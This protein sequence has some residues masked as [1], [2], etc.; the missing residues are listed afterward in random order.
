MDIHQKNC[1][2]LAFEHLYRAGYNIVLNR[3]G[4]VLYD[5]VRD[6]E[7]DYCAKNVIPKIAAHVTPNLVNIALGRTAAS[8]NERREM[9]ET[10]LRRLRDSWEDHNTAMNMIADVL[11]YL[12]RGLV[13]DSNRPSIYTTTI[14]LYRDH[15]L[16]GPLPTSPD[17]TVSYILNCIIIDLINM[18]RDGDVIDRSL[19][20][21]CIRML[22]SLYKTDMELEDEKLYFTGFEPVFLDATETYYKMECDKLFRKGDTVAWLRH[23]DRRLQEEQDRCD[24]TI[25]RDT[26]KQCIKIVEKQLIARHLADFLRLDTGIVSMLD[27]DSLDELAIVYRLVRRVDPQKSVLHDPLVGRI[28][29]LGLEIEQTIRNTDFAS[30]AGAA[31]TADGEDGGTGG[32]GGTGGGADSTDKPSNSSNKKGPS[33]ASAAAQQTAAAIKWV[34]DV[35]QL[36]AKFDTMWERCFEKDLDIQTMLTKG[37]AIFINRFSRASEYLSLFIDDNLRRGIRGKT[38]KEIDEVL[39]KAIALLRYI[40]DRDM[41]ERYYQKHLAK[42]LLLSKS[43]S[44]DAETAMVS[45]M[46][47]ELGNQF[48]NKFEGM[49]R[50]MKTSAEI[51]ANYRTHVRD[52]ADSAS[53][54]SEK[55]D[56]AR[57]PELTVNILT[58]NCWPPEISDRRQVLDSSVPSQVIYPAEIQALQQNLTSFYLTTRSGRKLTWVSSMGSA[59]IRCVF[60]AIPGGKGPLARERRYELNVSTAGMIVLMLFN[61]RPDDAEALSFQEI[62]EKTG[63]QPNDLQRTLS[64]L[65]IPP[66]SRVLLKEPASRRV[67]TT[68]RFRFNAAFVSKT[69]RIRAPIVNATAKAETDKERKDTEEKNTLS[70]SHII[71][72]A[73]V[74]TMKYV[75]FFLFPFFGCCFSLFPH[76]NN[77]LTI[78]PGNARSSNTPSSS[79]RL[80]ASWP[81]ASTPKSVISRNG[82]RTSSPGSI[83]LAW[84]TSMS[85]RT[86]TSRNLL[87]VT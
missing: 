37:F 75:F 30:Q 17:H 42:R 29:D 23:T 85:P 16:H 64:S 20:R 43:E 2:K 56:H 81:A 84:R 54:S 65:T 73:I 21:S 36:K 55:E 32:T 5:R 18:E 78:A 51:T 31:A 39:D 53:S 22:D 24:T 70:R 10:F 25:H 12:D 59:D 13:Q 57:R 48:T 74:R 34:D 35:L 87:D 15:I 72:A 86:S 6:F 79:P 69:V 1:S 47:E 33:A 83:W 27:N 41:F 44:Q 14:G 52:L 8:A 11:M 9:H 49:F 40:R 7:Q 63:I 71:D 76:D 77:Q 4:D 19:I 3:Q 60:P 26:L 50:D 67:E 62:Q 82:S 38:E 28:V 61:D 58:T 46:K 45:R 66:R 68:D 80:S